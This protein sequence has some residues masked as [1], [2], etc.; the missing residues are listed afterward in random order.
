MR[1]ATLAFLAA[2][3]TLTAV[4][5]ERPWVDAE[6]GI[7]VG[8]TITLAAAGQEPSVAP[9]GDGFVAAWLESTPDG[10]RRSPCIARSSAPAAGR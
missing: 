1:P 9:L 4:A 3:A 8:A 2:I 10:Q 7:H 5:G 6:P